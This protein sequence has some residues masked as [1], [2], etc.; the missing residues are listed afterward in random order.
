VELLGLDVGGVELV[1]GVEIGV[2]MLLPGV[3]SRR[4]RLCGSAAIRR[5]DHDGSGSGGKEWERELER[6]WSN[7]FLSDRGVG[8]E[9]EE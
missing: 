6:G 7:D 8:V 4:L 5:I 1:V 2:G 9:F 3:R